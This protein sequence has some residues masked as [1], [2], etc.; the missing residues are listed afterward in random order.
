MARLPPRVPQP[1]P[2][3]AGRRRHP[4]GAGAAGLP[5]AVHERRLDGG[6]A[7][8][9]AA[10]PRGLVHLHLV[11]GR[12]GAAGRAG[13]AGPVP[14]RRL[15]RARVDRERR[16][17]RRRD[18]RSRRA[19]RRRLRPRLDQP[20]LR[21]EPRRGGQRAGHAGVAAGRHQPRPL[22]GDQESRTPCRPR[23]ASSCSR[24]AAVQD[25]VSSEWGLE[26]YAYTILP[27]IWAY[28]TD[29]MRAARRRRCS[30][31]TRR[32]PSTSCT[33]TRRRRGARTARRSGS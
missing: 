33:G 24:A 5:V 32:A 11:D 15:E 18:R 6:A 30:R 9:R 23:A 26:K 28:I 22:H 14:A 21:R 31:A 27:G 7:R 13:H 16:R 29:W 10:Q 3:R 1:Q 19:S 8:R 25:F 17:A 20:E 2:A 12:Q 4:A